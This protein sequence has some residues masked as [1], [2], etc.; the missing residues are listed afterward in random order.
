MIQSLTYLINQ[1]KNS[2]ISFKANIP[3]APITSFKIGGK[4]PLVIEPHNI[5]SLLEVL[6]FLKQAELEYKILGGGTNILVSDH[7]DDF[8][9][10]RLEGE[11]KDYKDIGGGTF[12]I[13]GAALTTPV[14]RK[15][16]QLGFTGSEFLSTIPGRIGGAVIQNAGCY[17]GELF[18]IIKKIEFIHNSE[19]N[20]RTPDQV[21]HG[22]RVTEFKEKKDSMITSID[23]QLTPG[24]TEEIEFSLKEKRDKRNSSQPEN[25]KSAGSVFKNPKLLDENGKPIKSWQLIDAAGLR[26]R[27]KGGAEIS[28][29]HCNFIVNIGNATASDV[30][31]LIQ[32]ILESVLKTS[33]I[34][35]EKEIEYFGSIP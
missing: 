32:L 2:H 16:S 5:E 1:L 23:V 33:G 31:Y 13:G 29:E 20:Y 4:S 11:F 28:A 14:F 26:G 15:L 24:N 6:F 27:K 35:L 7:P 17:G 18:N 22:Y 9:V 19:I 25:K 21:R 3:L 8:V 30:D 34:L 12:R 10:I